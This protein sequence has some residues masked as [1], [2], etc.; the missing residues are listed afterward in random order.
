M[1]P[2]RLSV[3][4]TGPDGVAVHDTEEAPEGARRFELTYPDGGTVIVSIEVEDAAGSSTSG[5]ANAT[6]IP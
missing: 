2:Y 3:K 5:S 4:V 6:L 1:G